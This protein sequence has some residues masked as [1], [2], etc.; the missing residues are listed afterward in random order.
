MSLYEHFRKDE[1][2]FVD[3][4]IDWKQTAE[5][6]YR[7]K[8]TDFLDPRQQ[9]IIKQI[10]GNS[11]EVKVD[12]QGGHDATERKRALFYPDYLV[13]EKED[14]QIS[15]FEIEYPGKFVTLEHRHVLGALM[16]LGLKREKFGDIIT[17][18][19]RFQLIVAEEV[20]DYIKV[21]FQSAGKAKIKLKP[22]EE[23]D[24]LVQ[25]KSLEEKFITVSSMRLDTVIAEAFNLSRAKVKPL[26]TGEKVKV[27]WKVVD[28]PSY[29]LAKGDVL[30]VRGAGRCEILEMDGQTKKGKHRL[31]IGFPS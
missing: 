16:S 13:P 12:F 14:F 6:E 25:V 18:N 10:V 26:V 4:V 19:S 8:L 31:I 22:L 15:L 17:D 5:V 28:D 3:Q 7:A 29:P 23:E 30:S 11:E 9:Q 20:A 27:D 21:N 24:L 1:H 2:S